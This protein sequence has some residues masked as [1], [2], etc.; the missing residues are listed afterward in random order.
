MALHEENWLKEFE[1]NKEFFYRHSVDHIFA[2][3]NSEH[4][5]LP[6]FHYINNKHNN[7]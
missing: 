4:E 3:F 1:G 6:L 2:V 5:N 7:I